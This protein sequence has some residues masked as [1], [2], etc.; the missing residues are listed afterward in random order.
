MARSLKEILGLVKSPRHQLDD[1]LLD[2]D[3]D[4]AFKLVSEYPALKTERDRKTGRTVMSEAAGNGLTEAVRWL[5]AR[6]FTYD[7]R[8][9]DGAY[10]IHAAT[11]LMSR[12]IIEMLI[13]AGADPNTVDADGQTP[14]HWAA[15]IGATACCQALLAAGALPTLRNVHGETARDLVDPTL[16]DGTCAALLDTA[17]AAAKAGKDAKTQ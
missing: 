12:E 17:M 10:P 2:G 4:K 14:L 7:S 8:D 6:E 1:A 3:F 5:L 16:D 9:T 15:E 11:I 13:Q